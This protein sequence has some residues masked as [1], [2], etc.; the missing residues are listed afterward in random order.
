M[1]TKKKLNSLGLGVETVRG[2]ALLPKVYVRPK[3]QKTTKQK[4]IKVRF[5]FIFDVSAAMSNPQ[6]YFSKIREKFM[7]KMYLR[8]REWQRDNSKGRKKRVKKYK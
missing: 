7:E 8:L 3:R 1:L 5:D 6:D 4:T 2:G